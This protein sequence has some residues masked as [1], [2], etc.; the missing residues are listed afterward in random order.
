MSI[1]LSSLQF[2]PHHFGMNRAKHTFPNGWC[3]VV[4]DHRECIH[5]LCVGC[6][7]T[8][9]NFEVLVFEPN[10]R[11]SD[12]FNDDEFLNVENTR[13]DSI[14]NQVARM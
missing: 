5:S 3:V 14:L 7:K 8:H 4:F 13:V 1:E 10:G 2:E 9:N 6:L 11:Y 12:H